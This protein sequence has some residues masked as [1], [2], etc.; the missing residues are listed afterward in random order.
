MDRLLA[1]GHEPVVFDNL[2]HGKR[3]NIPACVPFILGDITNAE[4]V[5][6]TIKKGYD[7]IVHMAAQKSVVGSMAD[8]IRDAEINIVGTLNLLTSSAEFGVSRFAFAG[9]GGAIYGE[10][11]QRPTREDHQTEPESP[12]GISKLTGERYVQHFARRFGITAAIL[13]MAN[14]YGPRQDHNGEGGVVSI[15]SR[16]ALRG[17]AIDV[18]GDGEQTRDYVY[19]GDVADAFSLALKADQSTTVNIG[20]GRETS[21]NDLIRSIESAA[22]MQ[23]EI[24]HCPARD[25]EIRNSCLDVENAKR[26]L[27][28]TPSTSL[29]EGIAKTLEYFREI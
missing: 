13:R 1:D 6:A 22:G 8:P 25:G 19:V 27:A 18:F 10:T 20:T 7:A 14:V 17:Q 11:D 12:Y 16:R 24:N 2:V 15:F 9:T 5:A 28:W 23:F 26:L 3:S 29:D 21:L 4:L